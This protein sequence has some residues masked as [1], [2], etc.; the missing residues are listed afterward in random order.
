MNYIYITCN[1]MLHY[2]LCVCVWHAM[3]LN[4]YKPYI[5]GGTLK[6]LTMS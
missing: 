2:I 5:Y 4:Y 3:I 1:K 6:G